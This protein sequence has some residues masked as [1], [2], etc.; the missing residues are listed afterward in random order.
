VVLDVSVY[1]EVALIHCIMS[2]TH[3]LAPH[4]TGVKMKSRIKKELEIRELKEILDQ[5]IGRKMK[6]EDFRKGDNVI[7][8]RFGKGI[9][10]EICEGEYPITVEFEDSKRLTYTHVGRYN[11]T[12][13]LPSLYH[14]KGFAV[15]SIQPDR[16]PNL[17]VDTKVLVSDL[18]KMNIKKSRHFSHWKNGKI[19]C[20]ADGR[21]SF[22][23]KRIV[24]P[25]TE[26]DH[27]EL[28]DK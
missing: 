24:F 21:T 12:D 19:Q 15:L 22:S 8:I 10:I 2:L 20:F 23:S 3:R 6:N 17:E 13:Y 26:W 28:A 11:R 9:V 5:P 1:N 25:T 27:W 18:E 14:I 4:L 7:C 16:L